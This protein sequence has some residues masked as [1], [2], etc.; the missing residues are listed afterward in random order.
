MADE[1]KSEPQQAIAALIE[2]NGV[3]VRTASAMLAA[4]YPDQYTVMDE[5]ALRALGVDDEVN[6]QAEKRAQSN[7]KA[8]QEK[9]K[10][11]EEGKV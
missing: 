4:I 1:K 8:W 7:F 2:L 5:L 10:G 6:E 9:Q 11:A 3:Q